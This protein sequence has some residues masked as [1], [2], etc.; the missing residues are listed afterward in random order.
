MPVDAGS[1]SPLLARM[2]ELATKAERTGRAASKF[3]T[4]AEAAETARAYAARRDVRFLLDGGFSG[5]ERQCAVFVQPDWGQYDREKTL[6]AVQ[7]SH[8]EQDA[9]RHQDVLGSVLG[10]GLSRDVMGDIALSEGRAL[11]VCLA[12]LAE[13]ITDRIQKLGR[14]GVTAARVPL[15]ELPDLSTNLTEKQL[16]VASLRLDALVAGAFHLSRAEAT[17]LIESG[18]VRLD[19]Q[20]CLSPSRAPAEGAVISLRGKGRVK[21]LSVLDETKKGRLR[22]IIGCYGSCF[23]Q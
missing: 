22:L 8:R 11:F 19:H 21:L 12:P 4:P 13:Y 18:L 6:A 3:L 14:V 2:E 10:L 15:A 5:A 9:V 7:L 17:R 1:R 20:E 16:T 23:L